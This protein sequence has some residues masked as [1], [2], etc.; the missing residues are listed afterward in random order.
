MNRSL[1]PRVEILSQGDEIL[2][3]EIADGNASWLSQKLSELGFHVFRHTAVG[4]DL[5]DLI[6]VLREIA[7]RAQLCLGTGGLGPTVDDLTAEAVARA[8]G[9]PLREDPEALRQ[10][11]AWFARRGHPMPA[12]NRKQALLPAGAARID[13]HWG[14]APGFTLDQAGCRLVFLPG[15]PAEMK[16]MFDHWV[17]PELR[18]RFRPRPPPRVTLRVVGVGESLLQQRLAGIALPP[19]VRLGFRATPMENH[20]KLLFPHG[21]SKA[22]RDKVVAA[23][24]QTL[25][26][27]VFSIEDGNGESG[28][29]VEVVD[30]LMHRT[31]ASLAVLETVSCGHLA[32]WCSDRDWWHHGLVISDCRRAIAHFGIP[33]EEDPADLSSIAVTIAHRLRQDATHAL[34][35]LG[36]DQ[37]KENTS[38]S[39]RVAIAL[40][41]P[42]GV[43]GECRSFSG[44]AERGRI[45]TA[46]W[47][48][49][50]LRRTLST[51]SNG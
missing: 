19:G 22:E 10:I 1:P 8:F 25:G 35:A 23:I 48:L 16:A 18:E 43:V 3:G 6:A 50:L 36:S 15:V 37:S 29:L 45:S 42:G 14:T 9:R 31:G 21:F 28:N 5:G 12:V 7:G 2:T 51:T 20:V 39:L 40:A 38:H 46:V 33:T 44:D 32:Q 41:A 26:L 4:D 13:N 11:E 30:R 47:A 27:Q 24:R 49:D 17:A 34:A